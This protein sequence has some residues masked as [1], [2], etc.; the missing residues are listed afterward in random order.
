MDNGKKREII[1]K[2]KKEKKIQSN[3]FQIPQK[4]YP[5]KSFKT[6]YYFDKPLNL[7]RLTW[8]KQT[9]IFAL[10]P[11]KTK[12]TNPDILVGPTFRTV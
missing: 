12:Q 5:P 7:P 2:Y 8:Q 3:Q 1:P 6:L 10:P 11:L 9:S 4:K